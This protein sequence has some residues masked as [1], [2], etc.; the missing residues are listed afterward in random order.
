MLFLTHSNQTLKPTW[1]KPS[2]TVAFYGD[3]SVSNTTWQRDNLV[4]CVPPFAMH[5][6]RFPVKRFQC[7]KKVCESLD[8][9]FGELWKLYGCDQEKIDRDGISNFSGCYNF[10]NTRGSTHLSM[11]AFGAAID[12]DAERNPMHHGEISTGFITS[13]SAIVHIFKKYGWFWGGDFHDRKDPMHF[14]AV[15]R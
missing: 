10:R 2:E 11:H 7:H 14:E 9:I 8:V 13:E 4:M 3:P 12:F 1:P 6:G 15:S 5:F